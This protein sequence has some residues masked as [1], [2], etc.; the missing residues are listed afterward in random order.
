MYYRKCPTCGANLDP[1]EICQECREKESAAP[2]VADREGGDV[3]VPQAL[4]VY[5]KTRRKSNGK[6]TNHG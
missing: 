3:G 1:G 5:Q 4:L 2:G 6:I